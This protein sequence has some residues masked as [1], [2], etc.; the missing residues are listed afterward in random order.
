M[1]TFTTMAALIY[2]A[3]TQDYWALTSPVVML[4]IH[5]FVAFLLECPNLNNYDFIDERNKIKGE[6]FNSEFFEVEIQDKKDEE[7]ER[8]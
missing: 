6:H 1:F 5:F 2:T 8:I 7:L 3:I 4:I